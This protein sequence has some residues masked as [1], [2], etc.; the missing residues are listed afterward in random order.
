MSFTLVPLKRV[1]RLEL[2]PVPVEAHEEYPIVGVL[3][4]GRG[5][6][7]RDAVTTDSTKY[8]QLNRV[9]EG[10]VIYSKLKAF[11][12]AITVVPPMPTRV[13]ASSEFP[14]FACLNIIE[15]AFMKL[16][17][18]QPSLWEEMALL[19]KGLG[20]R[21]ERISPDDFLS[22]SILLPSLEEQRR[23]VDLMGTLDDAIEAAARQESNAAVVTTQLRR[24][25]YGAGNLPSSTIGAVA[26]LT[27][28][29]QKN[30]NGTGSYPYIRAANL[31]GGRLSTDD[32]SSMPFSDLERRRMA[33]LEG[34]VLLVEGGGGYGHSAMWT[35]KHDGFVGIQNSIIR[36]RAIVGR[37]DPQYL[38]HWAKWARES[39]AFDDS[40]TS[41]TI[42][43]LSLSRVKTMQIPSRELEAQ[44]IIVEPIE[45][46]TAV[47]E[48]A[49]LQKEALRDLRAQLLSALLSGAHRI[50]EKYDELMGA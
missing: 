43:H 4:R 22:L 3:N 36:L 47:S 24:S 2:H 37:S 5:I 16:I 39:G 35:F 32:L 45:A 13:Y 46:A 41:T 8:K 14:T 26:D 23:I 17:T 7:T 30:S 31:S 20:G 6:L 33:L 21:R 9:S 10:S 40:M 44:R 42:P 49:R 50:P 25:A 48:S 19:S 34:D 18:Q 11:E 38:L 15:P 1:L 29:K 28:G 27:I 12:G